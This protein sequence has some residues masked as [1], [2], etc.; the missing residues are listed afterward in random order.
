MGGE[1]VRVGR[2]EKRGD[3]GIEGKAEIEKAFPIISTYTTLPTGVGE[4]V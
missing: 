1:R 2:S 3:E 4:G